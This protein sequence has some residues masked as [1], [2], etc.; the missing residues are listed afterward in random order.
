[1]PTSS[2]PDN[3][4]AW[5]KGDLPADPP[6]TG[7]EPTAAEAPD[8]SPEAAATDQA[9]LDEP[10]NSP[11]DAADL[12]PDPQESESPDPYDSGD[13]SAEPGGA[14]WAASFSCWRCW[15]V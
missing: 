12:L 4:P 3:T 10:V 9:S 5:I 15:S 8:S 11:G 1:M 6:E 14:R 13:P 7:A 2:A